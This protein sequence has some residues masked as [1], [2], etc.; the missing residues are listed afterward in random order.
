MDT[1]LKVVDAVRIRGGFFNLT[2]AVKENII[3][4]DSSFLPPEEYFADVL[5]L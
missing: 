3:L 1:A 4:C 2:F 5:A